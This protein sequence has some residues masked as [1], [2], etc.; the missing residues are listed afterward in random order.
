LHAIQ[1]G[2]IILNIKRKKFMNGQWNFLKATGLSRIAIPVLICTLCAQASGNEAI[3]NRMP[4]E[5]VEFRDCLQEVPPGSGFR[6]EGYYVWGG[7]VIKEGS[8]YHLFASRWPKVSEFPDGYRDHSEIVRATSDTLTGPYTFQEVVIGEREKRF[9][10][11]NMAHNPTIHRIGDKYVLFY[12]GSDFTTMHP[13]KPIRFRRIGYAESSSIEGP[14]IRSD[15]PI[16]EEESNNP[17]VLIEPDGGIL[18]MFRDADLHVAMAKAATYKE[19]FEIVRRDIFPGVKLED[20]YLYKKDGKYR[21]ILEDNV[22][23][24]TGHVRWGADLVSD[25]G[26]DNWRSHNPVIVY[27][28]DIKFTD[29]TILHCNR[30]ERPQLF[31][32]DGKVQAILTGVYDG[33]DSWCQPVL[34]DPRY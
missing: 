28:H 15:N 21:C 20:F 3:M 23:K 22:G 5:R 27:D 33:E 18:M 6:M 17:A 13:E 12:I 32:Q 7:S 34:L 24:L 29:G 14:W 16:I 19:P 10:D 4:T 1:F 31:I 11:S 26:L 30:R 9:W 2:G 8:T 25:N